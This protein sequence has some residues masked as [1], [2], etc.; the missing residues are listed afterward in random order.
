M[1]DSR[2]RVSAGGTSEAPPGPYP[3]APDYAP[4]PRALAYAPSTGAA[5]WISSACSPVTR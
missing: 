1:C 5:A 2:T 4:A 3:H